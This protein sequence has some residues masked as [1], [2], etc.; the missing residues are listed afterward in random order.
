MRVID[1]LTVL[2]IYRICVGV[3]G[4]GLAMADA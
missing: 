2:I 4:S 3:A 1:I